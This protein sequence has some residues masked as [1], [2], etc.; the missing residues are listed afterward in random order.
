MGFFSGISNTWNDIK[1]YSKTMKQQS[2][3]IA[4]QTSNV[5]KDLSNSMKKKV[6]QAGKKAA[7]KTK[8]SES[9]T[10]RGGGNR[11][12]KRHRS[13]RRGEIGRK[14]TKRRRRLHGR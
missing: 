9:L 4:S 5:M 13:T 1:K 6:G 10:M 11:R 14:Y 3:K 2:G 12:G 8:A 7:S